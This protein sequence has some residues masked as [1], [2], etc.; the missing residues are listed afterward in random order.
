MYVYFSNNILK[1]IITHRTISFLI[2]VDVLI[3]IYYFIS[4]MKQSVDRTGI[5]MLLYCIDIV[6]II[7]IKPKVIREA[8]SKKNCPVY[9]GVTKQGLEKLGYSCNL[10]SWRG[11]EHEPWQGVVVM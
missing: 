4:F 10:S 7:I 8:L 5:I 2:I 6:F 3:Y 11:L 9:W 1:E